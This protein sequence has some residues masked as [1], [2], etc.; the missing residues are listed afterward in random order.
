[1]VMRDHELSARQFHKSKVNIRVLYGI[2]QV[3]ATET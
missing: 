1:M 2:F 3:K